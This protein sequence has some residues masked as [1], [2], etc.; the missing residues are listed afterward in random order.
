MA[1]KLASRLKIEGTL[2]A[3]TPIHVGGLGDD[4]TVDLALAVNGQGQYYIPGTSLAGALRGWLGIDENSG[5]TEA[6]VLQTLWGFQPHKQRRQGH[7]SHVLVEDA[8]LPDAQVEIRDG[9]GID[10]ETGTAAENIK[11][12]RAI[13][14]K[15]TRIPLRMILECPVQPAN[16]QPQGADLWERAEVLFIQTLQA[17]QT[18]EIRLGAAKTRGLGQVQLQNLTLLKQPLNTFAGMVKTLRNQGETLNLADWSLGDALLCPRPQLQITIHWQPVGPVMVKAE[19][20]G[21]AV[22][23]LPLVSAVDQHQVS[24]VIP[25]SSLKG[26]L[27]AQAERILRTLLGV[28]IPT[29]ENPRQRFLQQTQDLPL[30]QAL[31]GGAARLKDGQQQGRIGA[32]SANDCYAQPQIEPA[33]WR[34]IES[35]RDDHQLRQ[36]LN[37]ANLNSVQ[38]AYHVAIDRWTGGAAEGFLYSTLEPMGVSWHPLELTLD[39]SRLSESKE[40]RAAIALLLLLLRDLAHGRIPLGYGTNRGM[41]AI[42]VQNINIKGRG[43]PETLSALED[44]YLPQGNITAINADCLNSLTKE[45]KDYYLKQQGEAP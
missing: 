44:I 2:L 13:L 35:A 3:Q 10:R 41:G 27:R 31:F 43:L 23:S 7:A 39:L 45:W 42:A 19:A 20:D 37:Q 38:Q 28:P 36:A 16:P 18:A 5:S 32:F 33:Q 22:D 6:K 4:P 8:P 15:G 17:L 21:I 12:D 25:G 1:R 14:A 11:F 29:N 24:L 34:S 40:Q 30:I 26:T 9:V